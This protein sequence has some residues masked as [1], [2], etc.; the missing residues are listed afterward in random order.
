MK[1]HD[2][3]QVIETFSLG[4]ENLSSKT[5][6]KREASEKGEVVCRNRSRGWGGVG[7]GWGRGISGAACRGQRKGTHGVLRLI[8]NSHSKKPCAKAAMLH[9]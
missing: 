4:R 9:T 8:V 3:E 6:L 7:A 2:R 5:G 1:V